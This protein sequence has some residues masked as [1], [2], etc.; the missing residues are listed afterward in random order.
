MITKNTPWLG[1]DLEKCE[2]AFV[3]AFV[4]KPAPRPIEA[5]IVADLKAA[6]QSAGVKHCQWQKQRPEFI[7]GAGRR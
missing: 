2:A 3:K 7:E 1:W 5:E 6:M 4:E